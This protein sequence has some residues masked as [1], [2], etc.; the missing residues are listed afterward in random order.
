MQSTA[1]TYS[2]TFRRALAET[3]TYEGGWSDD[4][5]DPGGATN[6][7]I[8]IKTY[9][10]HVGAP[11]DGVSL[12]ILREELRN[13]DFQTVA[14]IYH[15]NYWQLIR[16]DELPPA[17]AAAL[18]DFAVNSGPPRAIRHLQRALGVAEDGHM[19]P[20]TIAAVRGSDQAAIVRSLMSTRRTFL[21]ALPHFW[22][23]GKGWLARCDGVERSCLGGPML[24]NENSVAGPWSADVAPALGLVS[25]DPDKQ[26]ASQGRATATEAS[27]MTASTTGRAAEVAGGVSGVQIGT[28]VAGAMAR[29]QTGG[30]PLD[31]MALLL[32]LAQRPTF[33]LAVAGVASAAYVW[34]ERRR[35]N[36]MG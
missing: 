4:L 3:L 21:R 10:A 25:A 2:P 17:I 29:V 28:D 30:K 7:G 24:A 22:R 34:F 27:T 35:K 19:G 11:I 14:E 31:L 32:D 36:V 9:A 6:K 33:W 26:S 13:I 23:F 18:F 5:F 20:V 1:A 15:A 8:T 12:E 16:G